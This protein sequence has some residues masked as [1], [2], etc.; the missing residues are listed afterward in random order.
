MN[1]QPSAPLLLRNHEA[2][3]HDQANYF[4]TRPYARTPG[5]FFNN[6]AN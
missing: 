4:N 6:S 5:Y 1:R 2:A 3:L